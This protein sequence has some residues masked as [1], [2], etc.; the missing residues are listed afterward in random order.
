MKR[1]LIIVFGFG[2]TLTSCLPFLNCVTGNG[3][4]VNERRSP[5]TFDYI[6][7]ATAIDVI[8][9]TADTFGIMIEAEENII[10]YIV[11]EVSGNTLEIRHRQGVSCINHTRSPLIRV[12]AP[13]FEGVILSGSGD[14]S[15]DI[16]D[17]S[18]AVVR[19]SGSGNIILNQIDA[20]SVQ[21]RLSGS[22]D[23]TVREMNCT[24]AEIIISG[25]GDAAITGAA[26]N[27]IF[28]LTGSGDSYSRDFIV[29][30]VSATLS[31]SGNL[32]THVITQLNAILSGSGNIYL[33]GNPSVYA[34]ITGSGKIIENKQ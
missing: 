9:T 12:S 2:V 6:V 7:N 21:L 1:L 27:G 33:R 13:V 11:T 15:G 17:C 34:T 3:R 18:D 14:V 8:F 25:S 24:D 20:E 31:G 30:R 23:L 19:I 28:T 5:A 16:I 4:L 10:P 29:T 26:A 32:H 22:G